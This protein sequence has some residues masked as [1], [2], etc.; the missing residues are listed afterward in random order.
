MTIDVFTPKLKA[1]NETN[2]IH[3]ISLFLGHLTGLSHQSQNKTAIFFTQMYKGHASRAHAPLSTLY[4]DI[5]ALLRDTSAAEELG[6]PAPRDLGGSSRKFFRD[7]FPVVYHN[8]LKLSNKQ[9]TPEYEVCLRD[10]YDAAQPFGDLPHQVS[11]LLRG[12]SQ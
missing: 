1:A 3:N 11:N 4:D 9:F 7:V 12:L 8:V 2:A 6:S 10:A 5:R